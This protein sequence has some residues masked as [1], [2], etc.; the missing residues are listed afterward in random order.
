[1]ILLNLKSI[2][3][4]LLITGFKKINP[5]NFTTAFSAAKENYFYWQFE[6]SRGKNLEPLLKI[7]LTYVV[8]KIITYF[9]S[10]L[11]VKMCTF[12]ASFHD[13]SFSYEGIISTYVYHFL[14]NFLQ[15]LL[16]DACQLDKST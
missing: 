16:H 4:L 15:N 14:R 11:L 13:I 12:E 6:I 2:R 1:M 9:P 8:F 10:F 7:R 5:P 3:L